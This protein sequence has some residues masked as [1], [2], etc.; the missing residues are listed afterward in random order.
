MKIQ[1]TN[2]TD[3][4]LSQ[5]PIEKK[6]KPTSP[7]E[8]KGLLFAQLMS[9]KKSLKTHL[10][11]TIS[12]PVLNS[13]E[14][15]K[16]KAQPQPV[17]A[18]SNHHNNI[19]SSGEA[20]KKQQAYIGNPFARESYSYGSGEIKLTLEKKFSVGNT[21]PYDRE[22]P[23]KPTSQGAESL[24]VDRQSNNTGIEKGAYLSPNSKEIEASNADF[25]EGKSASY[26]QSSIITKGEGAITKDDSVES[27]SFVEQQKKRQP[28]PVLADKSMLAEVEK[29]AE[30]TMPVSLVELANK[31]QASL[32]QKMDVVIPT[33]YSP[34]HGSNERFYISEKIEKNTLSTKP[35]SRELAMESIS[36]E[37]IA[38]SQQYWQSDKAVEPS[39]N[40]EQ[41]VFAVVAKQQ[42][43]NLQTAIHSIDVYRVKPDLA[44][45]R[46]KPQLNSFLTQFAERK[47]VENSKFIS[48]THQRIEVN[49][50]MPHVLST[51]LPERKVSYN[52]KPIAR[53]ED[54]HFVSDIKT[55]FFAEKK[56]G[57][58]TRI[59]DSIQVSEGAYKPD[60]IQSADIKMISFLSHADIKNQVIEVDRLIAAKGIFVA[61]QLSHFS[62]RKHGFNPVATQSSQ[63]LSDNHISLRKDAMSSSEKAKSSASTSPGLNHFQSFITELNATNHSDKQLS[64]SSNLTNRGELM[65]AKAEPVHL[66]VTENV[67]D[68]EI[69]HS[70]DIAS[71]AKLTSAQSLIP[72]PNLLF[73]QIVSQT[74]TENIDFQSLSAQVIASIDLSKAKSGEEMIVRLSHQ[75]FSGSEIHFK[76]ENN[77]FMMTFSAKDSESA[78]LAQLFLPDLK[79]ILE[80]KFPQLRHEYSVKDEASSR[81][82]RKEHDTKNKNKPFEEKDEEDK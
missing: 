10:K 63:V 4:V 64:Q 68:T 39:V 48:E 27:L 40:R 36:S 23:I 56:S 19:L 54:S 14:L 57:E 11:E 6:H 59:N 49:Q 26:I 73:Q 21:D 41:I 46:Q 22:S 31:K 17:Y 29:K 55:D 44:E 69:K 58:L 82:D 15:K 33:E 45:P 32:T 74:K 71:T 12:Q 24:R 8:E 30:A 77:I 37:R 65:I 9:D 76:L 51:E 50:N 75:S 81:D 18:L 3:I 25:S 1:S 16:H 66:N 35:V 67:K 34:A 43:D 61:E 42:V 80:E 5:T 38:N 2:E 70:L 62:N 20:E 60:N 78:Q 28:E 53:S 52:H 13:V 7:A 72:T 47:T 79:A